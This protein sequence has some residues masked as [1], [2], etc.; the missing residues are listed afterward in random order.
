MQYT[1]SFVMRGKEK[2][3]RERF[4]FEMSHFTV[5]ASETP[6][7]CTGSNKIKN[8]S[9]PPGSAS[10]ISQEMLFYG[11][12]MRAKIGAVNRES[13]YYLGST[14]VQPCITRFNSP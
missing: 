11:H 13:M 10:K 1:I 6:E 3:E 2:M 7:T 9:I 4:S 12:P 14:M 8:E 5:M